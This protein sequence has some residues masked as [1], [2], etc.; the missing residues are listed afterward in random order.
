MEAIEVRT[1][2]LP[3]MRVAAALGFGP[4]PELL[5]WRAVMDWV[6]AQGIQAGGPG[7][8]FFGFNN[9]NP[10][11]GSPN[12]GYE[13]WVTAGPG[14]QAAGEV[15]L[16]DVPGGTYLVT[17]CRLRNITPAWQALVAWAEDNGRTLR[18]GQCL[19][20]CLGD[21]GAGVD[22]ESEFDLYL[23]VLD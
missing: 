9:P 21:P 8:R 12:Y 6:R 19:E 2:L 3:P 16:K 14:A 10:A 15:T 23:P 4:S 18:D 20:E 1:V 5:A 17:R 22:E 11:P 13:Q 7:P